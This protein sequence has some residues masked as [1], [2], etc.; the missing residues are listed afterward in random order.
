MIC[1]TIKAVHLNA[2]EA[3][4]KPFEYRAYNEYWRKRIEGKLH[5]AIIF[6]SGP[7]IKGFKV[8]T[9][10]VV[11]TPAKHRELLGTDKCFAIELG[12]ALNGLAR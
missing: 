5:G 11:K 12:G 6:I 10:S 7:R 4:L 2:I 8:K 3:G 1:T 9:I